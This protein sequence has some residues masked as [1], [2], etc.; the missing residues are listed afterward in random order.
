MNI[1]IVMMVV[2]ALVIMVGVGLNV[3]SEYNFY[4]HCKMP[5]L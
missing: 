4:N 3:Y 1:F 5:I 2:I